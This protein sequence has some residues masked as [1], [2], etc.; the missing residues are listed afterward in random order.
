MHAIWRQHVH[1]RP[2]VQVTV[3]TRPCAATCVRTCCCT[4]LLYRSHPC[5]ADPP[6]LR[7]RPDQRQLLHPRLQVRA[8]QRTTDLIHQAG[9]PALRQPL[10]HSRQPSQLPTQSLAG[11]GAPGARRGCTE[12]PLLPSSAYPAAHDNAGRRIDSH[13]RLADSAPETS[14]RGS[15]RKLSARPDRVIHG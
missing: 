13:D 9:P 8:A 11:K 10:P 12:L 15:A 14:L 2:S 4:F 6:W 1:P 7:G 3:L 5:Q